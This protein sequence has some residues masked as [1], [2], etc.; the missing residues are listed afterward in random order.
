MTMR[1]R[2][3]PPEPHDRTGARQPTRLGFDSLL[4]PS[5]AFGH[6]QQVVDDPDLTLNEKRAILAA[7]VSDSCAVNV[8][9]GLRPAPSQPVRFDDI[10]DALR[11]L[12]DQAAHD[13]Q[14]RP[15]YRRVL[16]RRAKP[17]G[18]TN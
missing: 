5:G 9:P 13:N 1:G 16:G 2:A 4:H 8:S 18:R 15:H 11:E 6:P 7:W 14:P 12:D 3:R 10:M 17:D